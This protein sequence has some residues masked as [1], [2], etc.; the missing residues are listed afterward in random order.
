MA[1]AFERLGV[2]LPSLVTYLINF[3]ILPGI[4]TWSRTA[5]TCAS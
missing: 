4:L 2:N 5:H 3:G 1:E